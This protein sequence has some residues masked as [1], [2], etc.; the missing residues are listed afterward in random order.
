MPSVLIR[1]WLVVKNLRICHACVVIQ[2]G[3]FALAFK[4]VHFPGEI[5]VARYV[6]LSYVGRTRL[7]LSCVCLLIQ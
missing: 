3:A 2:E 1:C 6:A 4:S 7:I 5:V